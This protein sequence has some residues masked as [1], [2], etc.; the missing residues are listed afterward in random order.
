MRPYKVLLFIICV[1]VS[2]AALCVVLPER[3]AFG[4]KELR[5]P[6][7]A[8]VI[9]TE[10]AYPQPLPEEEGSITSPDTI[11]PSPDTL[12]SLRGRRVF[13]PSPSTG[14]VPAS[15]SMGSIRIGSMFSTWNRCFTTIPRINLEER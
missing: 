8:E 15:W 1:M 6:T 11:A 13:M 2:L 10:E 14:V 4:E 7:L 9:G 12:P 3:F 5:W